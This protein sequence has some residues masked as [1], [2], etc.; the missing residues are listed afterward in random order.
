MMAAQI[1]GGRSSLF[2]LVLALFISDQEP[3]T[4]RIS[5]EP[6]PGYFSPHSSAS[7]QHLNGSQEFMMPVVSKVYSNFRI[8]PNTCW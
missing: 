5:D 2:Q 7:G 8:T 3:N 4:S 1:V 6:E